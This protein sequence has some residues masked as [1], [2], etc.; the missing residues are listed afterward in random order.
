MTRKK[1]DRGRYTAK[2]KAEAV[3]RLVKGE[4]LD[5]LSRELGVTASTLSDWRDAF[6]AG[7]ESN[8]KS[9]DT[10]AADDE[11]MRLKAKVGELTMDNE[12]LRMRAGIDPF[13]FRK[14]KP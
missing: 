14:S 7:G 1:E 13:P 6:L 9:R 4:S 5:T 2:R 12:L 3:V 8:L 10:T 11:V